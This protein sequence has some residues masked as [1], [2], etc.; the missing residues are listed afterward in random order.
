MGGVNIAATLTWF[1]QHSLRPWVQYYMGLESLHE[2]LEVQSE[3][4]ELVETAFD[5][6]NRQ[7]LAILV[8]RP[9]HYQKHLE[10]P[11]LAHDH[12]SEAHL[13]ACRCHDPSL[14]R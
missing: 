13:Q 9:S 1:F 12:M 8:L 10:F 7:G 6:G 3:Q 11:V 14:S 2:L 4:Q 5:G